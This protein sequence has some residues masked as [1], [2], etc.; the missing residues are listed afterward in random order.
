MATV[1][2][3]STLL[4]MILIVRL[5]TLSAAP[6]PLQLAGIAL[7]VLSESLLAMY[8]RSVRI[9]VGADGLHLRQWRGTRFIPV[10]DFLGIVHDERTV[11]LTAR[12][13]P[14]LFLKASGERTHAVDPLV[15]AV[16]DVLGPVKP[17]THH[18]LLERGDRSAS[19]WVAH[20]RG[21]ASA[22]T[23][24]AQSVSP[25]RLWAMVE[26]ASL[27][28]PHRAAAAVALHGVLDE[29][30]RQRLR[31]AAEGCASPKVRAS[32]EAAAEGK[33]E[34]VVAALEGL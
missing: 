16:N 15:L 10:R 25:E 24:R 31:V 21:V 2:R 9:T 3:V 33:E 7:A 1:T 19:Q 13:M 4:L 34:E 14:P 23:Y 8:Y 32:M 12:D 22:D 18:A 17:S 29:V 28:P 11:T 20:L 27:D 5:V 26:D 30:G 6:E